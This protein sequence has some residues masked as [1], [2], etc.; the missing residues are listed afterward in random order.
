MKPSLK[1][2]FGFGITSGIITTLGLI[3]GLQAGT[4]SRSVVIGG[5]LAIAIADSI[6]D[7]LGVHVSEES[8][9]K[10]PEKDVWLSTLSA[11][12]AKFIFAMTF[13]VPIL[14][15]QLTTAVI[16][17]VIWGL[18]VL[19]ISS[20]YVAKVQ[21]VKPWKVIVK[22]LLIATIVVVATQ[23]TGDWIEKTFG[24]CI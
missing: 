21:E 5:I 3:V 7:A 17:S 9:E 4:H 18:S 20:L 15:F 14:L 6:S 13:V 22:H 1:I 16:V 19:T 10:R 2:G 23:L 8:V 11:L 12:V 24:G